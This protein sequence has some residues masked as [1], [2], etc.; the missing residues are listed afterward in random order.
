MEPG[1]TAAERKG[2]APSF[3]QRRL[4]WLAWHVVL[5]WFTVVYRGRRFHMERIPRTGP[6]L[7]V[8][9]HQSHFDPPLIATCNPWRPTHFLARA[10][11]FK[12]RAFAWLITALNAVPIREESG[13][14]GAI[15]E[16]LARLALGV[17][18]LVFPEGSRTPDGN[19]Q[20]FKRGVAVLIK[21][22]RCPVVPMAV[23]GCFDAFPR[24]R[25]MPRLWGRRVAVMAGEPIWPEE[26]FRD[27]PEAALARLEREVAALQRDLQRKL[28][29]GG[30]RSAGRLGHSHRGGI[31]V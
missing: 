23:E 21:R 18:V 19:L 24:Q 17:P 4:Y 3:L 1:S 16:I 12:K 2:H 11:L 22:A 26:L 28:V 30:G 27:G 5:L 10:G 6:L 14:L 25:S 15:R 20:E 13:D 29:A 31:A 9:N 8:S 7:L